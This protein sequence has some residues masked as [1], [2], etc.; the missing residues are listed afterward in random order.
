MD[1]FGYFIGSEAL[2][3]K[4]AQLLFGRL[5]VRPE[6]DKGGDD[7]PPGRIR[8][9]DDARL[10]DG[11][12]RTERLFHLGRRNIRPATNDDVLHAAHKPVV[13]VCVLTCQV[14]DGYY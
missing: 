11:G 13:T 4:H 3:K 7:L 14:A 5:R 9:A 8:D 10:V 12:M 1:M 2:S 6:G